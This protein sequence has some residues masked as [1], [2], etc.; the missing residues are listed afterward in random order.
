MTEPEIDH[1]LVLHLLHGP[2]RRR[3]DT[4]A[5]MMVRGSE[6]EAL[7]VVDVGVLPRVEGV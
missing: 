3:V 6:E 4:V 2:G 7:A 1:S 5:K